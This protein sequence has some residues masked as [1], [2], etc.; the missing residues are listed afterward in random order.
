VLEERKVRRLGGNKEIPVD[1]RVLAATNKDPFEAI[2]TGDFREDL[3]YRLNV[4]S[5]PLPPLRDRKE[6]LPLLA[7][8]LI[9]QLSAKH[10]RPARF[11]SP[12]ALAVLQTHDW[13]GNVRELRNAI[14]RAVVICPG[15]EVQRS[16][17]AP[18]SLDQRSP[19]RPDGDTISFAVGTP[20]D[21]VERVLIFRTL[22]K[23]NNNKTKAAEMLGLSLKTLHNKLNSYRAQGLMPSN[24]GASAKSV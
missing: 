10:S 11:L 7:Q 5:L 17:L 22:Q 21:A 8:H 19:A 9:N 16:H 13:P 14:E 20:L 6:D 12:A 1:A 2:K 15:E 23:T 18:D 4:I 3:L 24:N